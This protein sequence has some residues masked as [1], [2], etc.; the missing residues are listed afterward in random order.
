MEVIDSDK[1]RI[2]ELRDIIDKNSELY[3]VED[4]PTL[5]DAEYDQL[6]LELKALEKKYPQWVTP[7]SPTQKVGGFA[8]E[9]SFAPVTH[10]VRMDSLQDVFSAEEVHDFCQK[11]KVDHPETQF[12]V[13]PKIDGLSVSLEYRD[14]VF[15]RGSTR[16]DGDTGE[17]VTENLRTVRTIPMRLTEPIPFIEVRGEVYMSRK[18]FLEAVEEQELNGQTPFKNPRNAAAGSL[19]QKKPAIT[20]KRKLDIFVFNVQQVEGLTLSGHKESLDTL[21]RLGFTVIPGYEKFEKIEEVEKRILEIG[22]QRNQYEYDI[23]GAVVKVDQFAEREELGRTS[24]Y[25]KW[26]VAFKYPPEEKETILRSIEISVGRTGVLTPTAVF[27]PI[28]LAGTTVSRASLHNQDYITEKDIRLGDRIKV[29][30]AGEIIPEVTGVIEHEENAIPYV[31]SDV[32][33]SCGEK[34]EHVE[35]EAALRCINPECP[36]TL[37][38]NIVHFASRDAMDIEG[39]GPAVVEQLLAEELIHSAADLYSLT[40]EQVKTLKKNGEKFA[41]NLIHSIEE[42]KNR[43]LGALLFGLGIR[44]IGKRASETLASTFKS[45]DA[46]IEAPISELVEVENFGEIMAENVKTFFAHEGSQK[47]IEELKAAGVNMYAETKEQG[48]QFTGLTFVLTGKLP[49]LTR[50]EAAKMIESA[51][52][53]VSGSVSKKTNFVLAGEDAGSKL[54]KAESLG[55]SVIDENQLR[56]MM[57][58]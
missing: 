55:I 20:K 35:G 13:E 53:K 48:T 17:D 7:D 18:S 8:L 26:A 34:A 40:V 27:D 46:I 9:N 33:P 36:A 58:E 23:D 28:N 57:K 39:L 1:N 37:L 15:V 4:N 47:L 54:V 29:H 6:M 25:P 16:G 42:S 32:C 12:V 3:Y 31:M 49:T 24:K 50:D 52:G 45:M 5:T 10:Q 14:G 51:G 19:R 41:Q 2:D 11:I 21:K 22:E 38:R 30:K 43:D 44:E 56:E